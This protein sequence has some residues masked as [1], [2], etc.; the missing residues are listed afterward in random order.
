[1]LHCLSSLLSGIFLAVKPVGPRPL[2]PASSSAGPV[3]L[4]Q[5]CFVMKGLAWILAYGHNCSV[6]ALVLLAPMLVTL[7]AHEMP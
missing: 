1:M 5:R 7:T 6:W 4:R 2:P 3:D